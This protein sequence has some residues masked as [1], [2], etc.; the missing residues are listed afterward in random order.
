VLPL[1]E[2]FVY[3]IFPRTLITIQTA[4]QT[5]IV[6][7]MMIKMATMEIKMA[8]AMTSMLIPKTKATT[9]TKAT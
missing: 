4:I 6:A 7:M 5:A 1:M 8:K 3:G 2:A 9:T